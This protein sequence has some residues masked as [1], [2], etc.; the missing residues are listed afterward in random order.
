MCQNKE[1]VSFANNGFY[2]ENKIYQVRLQH[3]TYKAVFNLLDQFLNFATHKNLMP[4]CLLFYCFESAIYREE[5]EK[6]N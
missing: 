6:I 4:F 3:K 1:N 5:I 2:A